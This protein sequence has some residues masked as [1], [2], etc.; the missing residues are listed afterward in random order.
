MARHYIGATSLIDG[1]ATFQYL[2]KGSGELKIK[3]SVKE[4]SETLFEDKGTS[5]SYNDNWTGSG[6][7]R[8][9]N[10]TDTKIV[11]TSAST[12]G[13]YVVPYSDNQI[14][15]FDMNIEDYSGNAISFRKGSTN[16]LQ[17]T[18]WNAGF[19]NKN[20]WEH[21]K[22]V[23]NN[24]T[25]SVSVN[26]IETYIGTLTN[27]FT[28]FLFRMQ[29]GYYI[30][31][32]NFIIYTLGSGEETISTPTPIL[33]TLFYDLL[34][35]YNSSKWSTTLSVTQADDGLI[36]AETSGTTTGFT[37]DFTAIEDVIIEFDAIG[38]TSSSNMRFQYKGTDNYINS[39]L[40]TGN[41]RHFKFV[42][43]NGSVTPYVDGSQK[44]AKSTT[45]STNCRFMLNNAS[46]K[47][48]NFKIYP[49]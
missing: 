29:D 22:I 41:V 45:S 31:Y 2:C 32:R 20:T 49:I 10:D 37:A 34:T 35:P 19:H 14:I 33:D 26:G 7:T 16:N 11:Q 5:T 42:C 40:F 30:K 43:T 36:I 13:F 48:K 15:E 39:Y 27:D 4:G 46:M 8:T 18:F 6:T 25:I 21:I 24:G 44:T 9:R 1:K 3:A 12:V 28:T 38:V 17:V 23:L 47:I